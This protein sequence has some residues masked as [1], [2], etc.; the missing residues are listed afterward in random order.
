MLMILRVFFGAAFVYGAMQMAEN[1]EKNLETGDLTNAFWVGYCVV[2]GIL[3]AAVW[4]PYIGEKISQPITGT[5]TRSTYVEQKNHLLRFIRW[6]ENHGH[7][8]LVVCFCFLE[9]IR[10]PWQPAAFLIGL[11]N[12]RPGSWLEKVYAR[13]V[14]KFGNAQN[15]LAAAQVLLRQGIQPGPHRNP[16][17]NLLLMTHDRA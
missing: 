12:A 9:G 17:V 3:N 4:A 11:K 6:L 5:I 10:R 8:R 16:E 2:V 14:F 1:A 15:C 7:R 13:E